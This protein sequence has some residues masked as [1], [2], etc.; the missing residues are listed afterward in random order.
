M[1]MIPDQTLKKKKSSGEREVDEEE[2]RS[3][4]PNLQIWIDLKEDRPRSSLWSAKARRNGGQKD[5]KPYVGDDVVWTFWRNPNPDK[6][7]PISRI[8]PEI[9][10]RSLHALH[11]EYGPN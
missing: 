7:S 9:S 1:E 4:T 5:Q 8:L 11:Y 6:I 2:N 3:G 10:A